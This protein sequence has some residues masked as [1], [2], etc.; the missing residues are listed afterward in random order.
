M[1]FSSSEV[2]GYMCCSWDDKTSSTT[3]TSRN[4]HKKLG[5]ENCSTWIL[6]TVCKL[7]CFEDFVGMTLIALFFLLSPPN[8]FLRVCFPTLFAAVLKNF[9]TLTTSAIFGTASFNKSAATRFAAG[10]ICL[11]KKGTAVLQFCSATNPRPYFP[12]IPR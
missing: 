11:R 1:Q 12:P 2:V 8:C 9:P 5:T 6:R 10:T 7:V 3:G 4:C